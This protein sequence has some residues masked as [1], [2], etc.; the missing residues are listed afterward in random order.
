MRG[1]TNEPVDAIAL[2]ATVLASLALADEATLAAEP[3]D[4]VSVDNN[5]IPMNP[6]QRDKMVFTDLTNEKWLACPS[7]ERSVES[8]AGDMVRI[9]LTAQHDRRRADNEVICPDQNVAQ[10]IRTVK[11][12][13]PCCYR[14]SPRQLASFLQTIHLVSP[15]EELA[16]RES[17]RARSA[18]TK[19]QK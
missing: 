2:A 17:N 5:T 3:W 7:I 4:R 12:S 14:I 18:T 10:T 19:R 16:Q 1:R 11:T 15:F 8:V 9:N 6:N 13:C